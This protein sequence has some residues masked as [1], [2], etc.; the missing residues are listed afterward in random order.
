MTH[1]VL[2]DHQ[3]IPVRQFLAILH[4]IYTFPSITLFQLLA[5]QTSLHRFDPSLAHVVLAL[6]ISDYATI[7]HSD[8]GHL[9]RRSRD[10]D[11]DFARQ[12][13]RIARWLGEI[14]GNRADR[15]M[16]KG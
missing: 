12:S 7:S 4:V 6:G 11:D 15:C 9:T 2:P 1:S 13:V 10:M 5:D 16:T 8:A 14:Q 3:D